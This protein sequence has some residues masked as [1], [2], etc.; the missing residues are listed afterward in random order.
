MPSILELKQLS[1]KF[2]PI[3]AIDNLSWTAE[4]GEIF[5]LLGPNGAGKTTTIRVISTVLAPTAG[6]AV[7]N[8]QDIVTDAVTARAQFGVLTA[9][10]GLYDRLSGR[11]N[12]RYTGRLYGLTG[13]KLERRINELVKTL[14]MEHFADRR[15]GKYSTGMKQKAAIARS[16]VHDPPVVIFDE[17]TAGLDVI[18][19]QT[20]V[21]MMKHFRDLGK[22]VVLST[23][24]MH[25]AEQLCDRVAIIHR[26]RLIA[27]GSVMDVK[28]QTQQPDLESAFLTMIGAN[29]AKAVL[30][31]AEEKS[32]DQSNEPKKLW[33]R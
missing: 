22:L 32:I 21:K 26:G 13:E 16:I 14:E 23:H 31:E 9:D 30:R 8:G 18:A 15:A 20:V 33:R 28:Q 27:L 2:G 24:D 5:G 6:T 29:E 25:S 19:A 10:F 11:E 1:K 12:I 4:V 7:V 3:Q 17:P